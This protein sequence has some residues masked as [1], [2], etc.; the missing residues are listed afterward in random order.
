MSIKVDDKIIETD[1]EGYLLNPDD[2]S[3]KVA[4]EMAF[5]QAQ[6]DNVKLTDTHWGL[7]QY[8]REYYDENMTHPTMHK[9]VMTLGKYHG[10]HFHEHE[11]YKAFLYG[12]FPHG[13]VP[14]LC[15]LAGLPKPAEEF[16]D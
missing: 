14:E 4:E 7:I 1:E 13:P 12:I 2:W 10:Q 16:E 11:T 3:E 15:K 5:Q 6:Q 9:L 8:F